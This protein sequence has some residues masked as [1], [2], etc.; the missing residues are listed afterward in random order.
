MMQ[1]VI[2]GSRLA[3]SFAYSAYKVLS[4]LE[5]GYKHNSLHRCSLSGLCA[6]SA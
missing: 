4:A 6:N 1:A 5:N 3:Y 2:L